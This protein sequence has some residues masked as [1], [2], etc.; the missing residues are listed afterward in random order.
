[1]KKRWAVLIVLG[2]FALGVVGTRLILGGG[3]R[4]MAHL[5]VSCMLLG[6]AEKAG[7]LDKVKRAALIDDLTHSK[8]L[9]SDTREVVANLNTGCHSYP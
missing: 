5:V 9:D 8:S 7:Y 1:M 4:R 3:P 2:G 6:E